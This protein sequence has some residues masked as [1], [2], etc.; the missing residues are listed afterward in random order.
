MAFSQATV[1][2]PNDWRYLTNKPFIF[3]GDDGHATLDAILADA[4]VTSGTVVVSD[5]Q[6]LDASSNRTQ[7]SGLFIQVINGGIITIPT[8]RTLTLTPKFDAGNYQTFDCVGTGKVVGLTYGKLR[9]WGATGDG[10]T[11]DTTAINAAI[12]CVLGSTGGVLEG[13]PR[14]SYLVEPITLNGGGATRG[15]TFDGRRSSL[16]QKTTGNVLNVTGSGARLDIKNWRITGQTGTKNGYGINLYVSAAGGLTNVNIS[17]TEVENFDRCVNWHQTLYSQM[18]SCILTTANTAI[19]MYKTSGSVNNYNEFRNLRI[20]NCLNPA[21]YVSEANTLK[22]D[23]VAIEG[24]TGRFFHFLDVA[25]VEINNCYL[26]GCATDNVTTEA[27]YLDL[28]NTFLFSN[29]RIP[30]N[31]AY[32]LTAT[33]RMVNSVNGVTFLNNYFYKSVTFPMLAD[34]GTVAGISFPSGN[35]FSQ[36]TGQDMGS[37]SYTIGTNSGGPSSGG[38]AMIV[39]MESLV[40]RDSRNI[41]N[42]AGTSGVIDA[43][44]A[45]TNCDIVTEV[46]GYG[47]LDAWK[48]SPTGVSPRAKVQADAVP[49][50]ILAGTYYGVYSMMVKT[51]TAQTIS[52]RCPLANVNFVLPGD[53]KWRQCIIVDTAQVNPG[54]FYAYYYSDTASTGNTW[55]AASEYRMFSSYA[56]ACQWIGAVGY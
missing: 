38:T 16:L 23:H 12:V 48:F 10:V 20:N 52:L 41:T 13:T 34:D 35:C 18:D 56:E 42:Y 43:I 22:F 8:G 37:T 14:D 9:W 29:N 36:G 28:C 25:Q 21:I 17:Q 44:L 19:Y 27:I 40:R 33:V 15:S 54:T 24:C 30:Q 11:E 26:D 47:T 5:V 6:T 49:A 51:D 4:A 2:P 55:F 39:P 46:G 50:A 45:Q 3:P 53:S 1:N 7:K 31:G 32:A